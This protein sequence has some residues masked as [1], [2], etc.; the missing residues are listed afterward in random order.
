[1]NKLDA[2]SLA[3]GFGIFIP[4]WAIITFATG[5]MESEPVL[6]VNF[7]LLLAVA[8]GTIAARYYNKHGEAWWL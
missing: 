3:L 7:M 4:I 2:K 8:C 6:Y 5:A 1:M